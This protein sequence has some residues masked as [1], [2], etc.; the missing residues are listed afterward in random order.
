[1]LNRVA[2]LEVERDCCERE[3]T[4][5][6]AAADESSHSILGE[7][8]Q[9][10]AVAEENARLKGALA[11][12][13]ASMRKMG[14]R[15]RELEDANVAMAQQLESVQRIATNSSVREAGIRTK[16]TSLAQLEAAYEKAQE[17]IAH[18]DGVAK[19]L[20][21]ANDDARRH[22]EALNQKAAK[23]RQ[24]IAELT[25]KNGELGQRLS[26]AEREKAKIAAAF[27]KMDLKMQAAL[28]Q[29]D[30]LQESLRLAH[31]KAEALRVE[32]DRIGQ[33]RDAAAA[34]AETRFKTLD[35]FEGRISALEDR[36]Q[37]YQMLVK[38]IHKTTSPNQRVPA[39]IQSFL[40]ST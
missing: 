33:D 27:Q 24:R 8:E 16:I 15:I 20:R 37:E 13:K 31:E 1:M 38:L 26:G 40:K 11:Q 12:S 25:A 9:R 23:M 39:S 22:T 17:E 5:L 6:R 3:L 2:E 14:D 35:D 7:Q 10:R 18:L 29:R 21:T 4:A 28:E 19:R 30:Q 36:N 34:K 32:L